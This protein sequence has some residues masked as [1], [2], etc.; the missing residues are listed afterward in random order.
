MRDT[1][2]R[3]SSVATVRV[4][5]H[6]TV[7]TARR[8]VFRAEVSFF[9]RDSRVMCVRSSLGQRPLYPRWFHLKLTNPGQSPV[10]NS[11]FPE[12]IVIF[13]NFGFVWF[14]ASCVSTGLGYVDMARVTHGHGPY[15]HGEI[16]DFQ[17]FLL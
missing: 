1:S 12:K 9:M 11:N 7:G 17:S 13:V 16:T 14:V 4:C 2:L 6:C 3:R 15:T 10:L 8:D 5:A